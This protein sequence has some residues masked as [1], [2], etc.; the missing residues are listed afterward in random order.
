MHSIFFVASENNDTHRTENDMKHL[1]H[2]VQAPILLGENRVWRFY[3]GGMMIE[4]LN[5]VYGADDGYFPEDWVGSTVQADNPDEYYREGEGIS[6]VDDGFSEPVPLNVI[7]DE[8]PLEMLGDAHIKSFGT[9]PALLVKLLD[10]SIRL[11]VHAH[12]HKTFAREHLNLRFG[13]T[14]AW[15]ILGTRPAIRDPYILLGFKES[16]TEERLQS[17]LDNQDIGMLLD[18]M[19]RLPIKAGDVVYVRG[20]VPHGI[21]E[22]TFMVEL[23]EPSDLNIFLE[24]SCGGFKIKEEDAYLGLPKELALSGIDTTCYTREEIQ[25]KFIIQPTV[26]RREGESIEYRLLGYD[27]TESFAASRLEIAG[28]MSDTTH[29]RYSIVII[30]NGE[31][32]IAHTH[33]EKKIGRGNRLFIP[34][35]I[36]DYEY[37]TTNRLTVM[38]CMPAQTVVDN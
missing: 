35:G 36:G 3:T 21:G 28:H 18:S 11:L 12:P 7:F 20:G 33:G 31:G 30:L 16:M 34:A 32:K 10:T 2:L 37:V 27:V 23:Q 14:E 24:R 38:K 25:E 8:Y 22:G 4:D 1:K 6:A 5:G 29:D 9:N 19:H 17:I 13:K 26:V 15:C